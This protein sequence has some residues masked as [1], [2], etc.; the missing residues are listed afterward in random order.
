MTMPMAV[1][2]V[3][4]DCSAWLELVDLARVAQCH[5]RVGGEHLRDVLVLRVDVAAVR[6]VEVEAPE[7]ALVVEEELHGHLG[8]EVVGRDGSPGERIGQRWS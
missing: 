7:R 5:G 2:M 6:G 1:P 3:R 8:P 4:L